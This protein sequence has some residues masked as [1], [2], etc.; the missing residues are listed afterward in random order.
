MLNKATA[1]LSKVALATTLLGLAAVANAGLI[2]ATASFDSSQNVMPSNPD[3]SDATGTAT[4]V[5]DSD[6]GLLSL[7]ASF[8]GVTLEEIT[9]PAGED[10]AF[11]AVGPLHIHN[12][13]AGAVGPIVVPFADESFFTDNGMGGFDVSAT[14]IPFDSDPDLDLLAELEAGNLYLNLH[15]PEFASGIIRGQLQ[16]PEPASLALLGGMLGLLGL[17]RRIKRG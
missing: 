5:F 8:D 13:P 3:L 15:T 4:I 1:A 14:D 12:A 16:A 10:L 11:G 9:F 2:T 7:T 6:T 17:R